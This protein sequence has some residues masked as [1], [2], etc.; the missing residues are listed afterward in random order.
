M[1]MPTEKVRKKNWIEEEILE[2]G[3]LYRRIQKSLK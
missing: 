2:E 1:S 3:I